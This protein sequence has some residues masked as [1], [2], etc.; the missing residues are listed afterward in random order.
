[1]QPTNQRSLQIIRLALLLFLLATGS[2]PACS[3]ATPTATQ[4]P[5]A[6][7]TALPP[8]PTATFSPTP[9]PLPTSTPAPT[10][11]ITP[12]PTPLLLVAA[13][14]P[15]PANLAPVTYRSAE[16]VSGLSEWSQETLTDLAWSPD[17]G[18][19]AASALDGLYM[20]D[21]QQQQ[22][23]RKIETEDN[24][25]SLAFHPNG[26]FLATGY[27]F[28]SEEDGY[29]GSV[30]FWRTAGWEAL[31]AF[32]S[33]N[34][35]V[36]NVAYAPNGKSFAAA[37]TSLQASDNRLLIW[38]TFTW[39]ISRTLRTGSLLELA[40]SPNGQQVA[41][42]P[43]RFAIKIWNLKDGT[44]LRSI[45]T[46]FTGAVNCLEYSPNGAWIA[47]GHYDG[48]VRIWDSQTGLLLRTLQA[49]GAGDVRV[50][51]SLAFNPG[52]LVLAAGY[53]Y[54]DNAV[55]LWDVETGLLLR[56]LEGHQAGVESLAF[57]PDGSMLA[58]GSYDGAIRLWG[59]RP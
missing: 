19:L 34:Q 27:R 57:S 58:S 43:D 1:M 26:N 59:V 44:L 40:Y 9:T 53:S 4:A 20:Y 48:A 54:V 29:G 36:S 25:Y 5:T 7:Q 11:T 38:D 41:T 16:Q 6:T 52:G 45:F 37:F 8:T 15:L 12:S 3:R 23:I 46:S 32:Y 10:P 56:T 17:G 22:R 47:S 13:G 50:V 30:E 33:E 21:P 35:V 55:R 39:E 18:L 51:E 31:G 42:T 28:G 14:T 2:L 24:I 49:N